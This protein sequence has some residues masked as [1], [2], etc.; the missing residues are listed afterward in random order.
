[1]L[2]NFE[3]EPPKATLRIAKFGHSCRLLRMMCLAVPSFV[4]VLYIHLN[5]A[6]SYAIVAPA[7]AAT[8]YL[9]MSNR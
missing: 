9:A 6:V 1:M 7:Y 4:V 8:F 3:K 5:P 2:A